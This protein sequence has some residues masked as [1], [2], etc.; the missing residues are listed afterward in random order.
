[1]PDV[2][3][4]RRLRINESQV[5]RHRADLG[6][7]AYAVPLR[8]CRVCDRPANC[9]AGFCHAHGERWR[10][11]G[12]PNPDEWAAAFLAGCLN[13]CAV[14]GRQWNGYHGC[15]HCSPECLAAWKREA[16]LARWHTMTPGQQQEAKARQMKRLRAKSAARLGPR[17]CVICG[18]VFDG[19]PWRRFCGPACRS[20]RST[21]INRETRRQQ[22][23]AR[24]HSQLDQAIQTIEEQSHE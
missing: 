23:R 12:K 17:T 15:R 3:I 22:Y 4:A 11:W 2:E 8:I 20:K 21:E 13:T 7:P 18:V 24:L 5:N 1:M 16:A 6:I 9:R 10:R 14:C 19:F